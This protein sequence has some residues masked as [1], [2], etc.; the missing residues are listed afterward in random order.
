MLDQSERGLVFAFARCLYWAFI[1]L[2]GLFFVLYNLPLSGHFF[3]V[4]RL[5]PVT[6]IKADSSGWRVGLFF[7]FILVYI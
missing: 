4:D 2:R 5:I 3:H 1:C 6:T 7:N